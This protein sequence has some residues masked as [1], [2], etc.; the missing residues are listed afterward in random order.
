[1]IMMKWYWIKIE[2]TIGIILELQPPAKR[3]PV[4]N[5]NGYKDSQH[6]HLKLINANNLGNVALASPVQMLEIERLA[7]DSFWNNSSNDGRS[8]CHQLESINYGI[9]IRGASRLSNKKIT[10]YHH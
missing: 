8:M 5:Q 7:T 1:M 10:T 3:Y 2:L 4:V 6:Q 9:D